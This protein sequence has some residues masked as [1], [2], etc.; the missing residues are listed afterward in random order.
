MGTPSRPTRAVTGWL[1]VL[2]ATVV[3][4][5]FTHLPIVTTL[6]AS[7]H[8]RATAIRPARFVGLDNYRSLAADPVFWK[9]MGNTVAFAFGTVPVSIALALAMALWVNRRIAGRGLL[10]LAFF[11]P[12]MLPMIAAANLWLFF[13]T[14]DIGLLDQCL[15]LAGLSGHNWLGDPSTALPCLM[16]VTIWKESGFFMIFYLAALQGLSAE[17]R[18]AA[19]LEGAGPVAYF[20][21]VLFP[22]L[23]PTTLFV[24]IN[25]VLNAFKMVDPLF[26][27]TKGGPSNASNLL[28]YYIYENAFSFND[29]ATAATLTVV[30]LGL[31]AVLAISQFVLL[32]RRVHYR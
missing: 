7:L 29:G 3:L 17:L 16:A 27:L 9:V 2:P 11:L 24:S 14:P 20:R 28:L 19:M 10:R 1:L 5:A 8:S 13:Y 23:M 25:A 26:I 21:R 31:L 22:L 15:G 12:T 4:A 6:I 18:E 30:L 32:D